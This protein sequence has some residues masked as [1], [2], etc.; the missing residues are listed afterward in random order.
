MT[1]FSVTIGDNLPAIIF[2]PLALCWSGLWREPPGARYRAIS[3][4]AFAVNEILSTVMMNQI[5]IQLL[6]FLLGGPLIDPKEIELGTRIPQSAK[7]PEAVWLGRLAPPS[8]LHTGL[9]VA[10]I[11]AVVIYL[12]LWRTPLGYKVRAVGQNKDASRYAGISVPLYLTLALTLSGGLAGLAGAV[13]LTGVS[14]RM[15][16]GFAVGY[17]FSGIVVALVRALA[18][19]GCDPFGFFLR[20]VADRRGADAARDSGTIGNHDRVAGSGGHFCG[21]Q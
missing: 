2:L 7:L 15:V 21:Q 20:R 13:E 3:R 1:A 14:R 10:L 11:A 5:A 18:S 16:E 19:P 17:G 6:L 12:L 9:F 4:R 8:R